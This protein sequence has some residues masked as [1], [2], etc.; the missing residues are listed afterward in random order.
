MLCLP[1]LAAL[2]P[3]EAEALLA[4]W[5]EACSD[6]RQ[7]WAFIRGRRPGH[8][9]VGGSPPW[10][11]AP[12]VG[13]GSEDLGRGDPYFTVFHRVDVPIEAATSE[14]RRL[15]EAVAEAADATGDHVHFSAVPLLAVEVVRQV[16]A[17]VAK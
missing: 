17:E 13:G 7:L 5:G 12:G 11:V 10:G 16:L 14:V 4:A 3:A 9:P 2:Q 6:A 8:F 1:G 15:L